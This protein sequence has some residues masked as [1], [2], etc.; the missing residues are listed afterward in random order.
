MTSTGIFLEYHGPLTSPV[1]DSLLTELKTKKEFNDLAYY[2]Q[3]TNLFLFVEC[4]EN[5]C[6]HSALKHY[7]R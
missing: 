5:I 2:N 4:I 1:V 7:G 6:K 3:E